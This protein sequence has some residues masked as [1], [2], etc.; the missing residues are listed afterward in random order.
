[1]ERIQ[2]KLWARE[3]TFRDTDVVDLKGDVHNNIYN[4]YSKEWQSAVDDPVCVI[5]VGMPRS[6]TSLVEQILGMHP[7]V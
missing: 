1:M 2:Q 3:S 4:G 6:G 5:I 7:L